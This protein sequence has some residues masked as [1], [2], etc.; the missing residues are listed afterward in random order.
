M[1]SFTEDDI[2]VSISRNG[3]FAMKVGFRQ[4]QGNVVK[5]AGNALEV[6]RNFTVLKLRSSPF[7]YSTFISKKSCSK[8]VRG[9]VK[10]HTRNI[11]K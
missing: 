6:C 9:D 8:D 5:N 4:S 2:G 7:T 1:M 11:T 10:L 3:N